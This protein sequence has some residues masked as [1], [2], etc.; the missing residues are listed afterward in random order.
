[1]ENKQGGVPSSFLLPKK[2]PSTPPTP[3]GMG[4]V[5]HTVRP[6]VPR[7][8]PRFSSSGHIPPDLIIPPPSSAPPEVR[9]EIAI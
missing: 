5:S 8:S 7:S 4:S 1:M 9:D 2:T 6:H 3:Q